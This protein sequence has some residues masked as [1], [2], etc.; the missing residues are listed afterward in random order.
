[1]VGGFCAGNG[2]WGG[3]FRFEGWGDSGGG[4]GGLAG[5]GD[6]DDFQVFEGDEECG[7]PEEGGDGFWVEGEGLGAEGFSGGGL[8]DVPGEGFSGECGVG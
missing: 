1:M 5:E 6:L 3:G 7:F 4:A 8:A 2:E